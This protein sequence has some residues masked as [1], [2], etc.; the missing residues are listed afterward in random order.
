MISAVKQHENGSSSG[1]TRAKRKSS[2]PSFNF[3]NEFFQGVPCRVTGS[4][5]LISRMFSCSLLFISTH[6]INRNRDSTRLFIANNST[7]NQLCF[8]FHLIFLHCKYFYL[9]TVHCYQEK[10]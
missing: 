9:S 2:I 5:I 8:T 10:S 1:H 3:F 7:M 4:R 6:L